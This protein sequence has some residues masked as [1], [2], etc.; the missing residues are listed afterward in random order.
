MKIEIGKLTFESKATAF[1]DARKLDAADV[2]LTPPA[3]D[4]WG[5]TLLDRTLAADW[6]DF[7]HKR[8][9]VRIVCK[10]EHATLSHLGRP[11]PEN[12]QLRLA[13]RPPG[14]AA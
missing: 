8:A 7:H 3:D 11:R 14:E 1:L 10:L 4:Q 2:L 6:R 5:R 12:R 9:D 13:R